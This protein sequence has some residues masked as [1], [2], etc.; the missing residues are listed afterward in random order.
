MRLGQILPGP[1]FRQDGKPHQHAVPHPDTSLGSVR[2][3]T[4]GREPKVVAQVHLTSGLKVEVHVYAAHYNSVWVSVEWTMTTSSHSSAGFPGPTC[5]ARQSEWHAGYVAR[6][7]R[8]RL[9]GVC[10]RQRAFRRLTVSGRSAAASGV[11]GACLSAA[12]T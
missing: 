11:N 4:Y 3:F 10:G 5:S 2:R 6:E 12:S 9:N 1:A 7:M 8:R